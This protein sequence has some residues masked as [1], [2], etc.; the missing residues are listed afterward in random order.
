MVGPYR[1]YD[2]NK[3]YIGIG[4]RLDLW[5]Y[6]CQVDTSF[7]TGKDV[8]LGCFISLVRTRPGGK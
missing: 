3:D 8:E 6:N 2:D 4:L 5:P 7:D 1:S